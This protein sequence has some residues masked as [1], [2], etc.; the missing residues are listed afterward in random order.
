MLKRLL[1][2]T[3]LLATPALA[4]QPIATVV[5]SCGSVTFTEGRPA[6]LTVDTTGA[7]CK[8]GGGG[9]GSPGGSNGQVQYNQAGNFGGITGATTNGTTLTLVAPVLGTPASGTLTN[10]T[11]LPLTSG[12][13]GV[14]P[15]ANGGTNASSASI[16][17][18]NNI[19]GFTAA[20]ATGTTSTNLVFSTSP[21]L[22]TPALGVAS[23]TSVNKVA[24]TAPA[25]SATLT[26]IDGTTL[27]GPA[28][29][30]TV[31]TLGNAE[32][33]S[34]VKT[35]ATGQ[36]VNGTLRLGTVSSVTG[37][38]LLANSASA[39]LTTIQAGNAAAA[40]TYTWPTNFGAAGTVLTD[41]A[42][43]GTLSWAAGGGI[44]EPLTLTRKLTITQGTANEGIL[45]STGYSLTGSNA[46]NMIDLAGTLNTS[47]N[48]VALKIALTN[49]A[50]GATTKFASFLAGASGTTEVFSV[51]KSGTITTAGDLIIPA[52]GLVTAGVSGQLYFGSGDFRIYANGV[53]NV[54]VGISS[55]KLTVDSGSYFGW[56]AGS[57]DAYNAGDV[58]LYRD[59]AAGILAQRNSTNAQTLRVYNT[60]TDASNYERGA[61]DWTTTANT[62]TIGTQAAGSGTARNMALVGALITIPGIATDATHT[63]A[64]VCEDTTTHALYN[65]SGTLGICLGTSSARYKHDIAP[66]SQS[67][68]Q[69]AALDPKSF[70]YIPGYGDNGVRTQYGFLAEDVETALPNLVGLDAEGRPNSVDILAMVPIIVNCLKEISAR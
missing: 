9:G 20:G 67:C 16:T 40:R 59:G 66:L 12:V 7:L 10:T 47:G 18:F 53:S 63:D 39:N 41:A 6:P 55:L 48:P 35:F 31:M 46:S 5:S 70:R 8:S 57:G 4:Q 21:T 64:S 23:A 17:S 60:Y 24:I 34:G 36:I 42:G 30:G 28:A 11:G 52:F 56:T 26:L 49:T 43:N 37:Q 2:L 58:Q 3:V 54:N 50:S 68:R 22:V 38:L 25:T 19:T 13:T 61:L 69:L 1:F 27:T 62:L 32:A 44:T 14:L 33:V 45:A 15:V 29:S 51:A 65:G